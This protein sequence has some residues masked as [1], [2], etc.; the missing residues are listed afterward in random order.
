MLQ[1]EKSSLLDTLNEH[2]KLLLALTVGG[3]QTH[4]YVAVQSASLLDF[5]LS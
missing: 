3:Q 1:S 2:S 5:I 4:R